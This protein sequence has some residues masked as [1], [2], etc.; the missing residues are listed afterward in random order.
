MPPAGFE[1]ALRED[2]PNETAG[3]E[4]DVDVPESLRRKLEELGRRPARGGK[5]TGGVS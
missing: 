1:P 4:H 5:R 2:K 3:T